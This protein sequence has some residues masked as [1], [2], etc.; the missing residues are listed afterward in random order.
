[1]SLRYKFKKADQIITGLNPAER[2]RLHNICQDIRRAENRLIEAAETILNNCAMR[3]QGL[4]CRN[5]QI[6]DIMTLLDCIHILETEPTLRRAIDQAV[7]QEGLYSNDCIFLK[8]G[9]GPCLF[10][11]DARPEKCILSFCRG[12]EIVAAELR[13]VRKGFNRL[14]GFVYFQKPRA[15]M[16]W[17]LAGKGTTPLNRD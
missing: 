5:I 9:V 16:R 6:D 10:P 13:Q 8:E 11:S 4:C 2:M 3:C 15:V 7:V 17:L 12:D 1:M 14:A